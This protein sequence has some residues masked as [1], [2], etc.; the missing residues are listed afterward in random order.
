MVETGGD[1]RAG[2]EHEEDLGQLVGAGMPEPAEQVGGDVADPLPLLDGEGPRGVG[3]VGVL[4]GGVDEL[5]PTEAGDGA[6]FDEGAGDLVEG[7]AGVV[8]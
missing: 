1:D 8:G 7:R 6:V 2:A 3:V 4:G 5:A